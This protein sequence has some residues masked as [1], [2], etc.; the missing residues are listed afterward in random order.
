MKDLTSLLGI[1]N[2]ESTESQSLET[3][4]SQLHQCFSKQDHYKV[5]CAI[6][7]LL[8]QAD[9]LP[10]PTQRLAAITLLHDL[11]RGELMAVNPFATVFIHLLHPPEE[12]SKGSTRKLEYA[13]QLPRLSTVEKNFLAQLI[14]NPTKE[15][16]KRTANQILSS[17]L[18]TF[19]S[20][21]I[22]S[23]QLALAERQS[24]LPHT[25]RSGIPVILPDSETR[26]GS[27]SLFPEQSVAKKNC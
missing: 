20:V 23:I 9:L 11:Y 15:L 19:H 13:G 18:A 22:T 8:Q 2:E 21:D 7:L 24:E 14:T 5:G 4:A 27:V 16:L 6:I 17:D 26:F 10:K 12:T 1:L 3:L 25:S